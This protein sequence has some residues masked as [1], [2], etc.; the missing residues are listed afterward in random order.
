MPKK[1]FTPLKAFILGVLNTYNQNMSGYDLIRIAKEWNYDHYIKAT[2][3][4]F[5]YTLSQLEDEK[6]IKEVG[7][8]QTENRPEQTIY[9]LLPKGRKEFIEQMD[10]FLETSQDYYFDLDAVS[11]FLA[12]YGILKKKTEILDSLMRQIKSRKDLLKH[13]EEGSDLVKQHY[14]FDVNPFMILPLEHFKVHN[15][16]EIKWLENF[17]KMVEDSNFEENAKE[18]MRRRKE[19]GEI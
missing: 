6:L 19:R 14:L 18:I 12:L 2:K 17:Y 8:K 11:P 1:R 4:S 13:L 3:A 10:Y 16:V 15:E 7:S 5:Y 9:Q